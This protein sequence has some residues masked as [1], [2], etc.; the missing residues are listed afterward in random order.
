VKLAGPD[1]KQARLFDTNR[2]GVWLMTE[3]VEAVGLAS[4]TVLL[5][6]AISAKPVDSLDHAYMKLSETFE[7]WRISHT[8]SIY[9]RV[10]YQQS[11]FWYPLNILGNKALNKQEQEIARNL[12]EDF[13]A[14]MS[15]QQGPTRG[16]NA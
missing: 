4:T 8:G 11:G 9:T 7:T 3:G 15:P 13:M 1:N 14:K 5:P 6:S 2:G 16:S 12:W 10:L